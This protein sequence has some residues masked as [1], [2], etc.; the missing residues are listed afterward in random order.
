M[1]LFASDVTRKIYP[2]FPTE[3]GTPHL[4]YRK[5]DVATPGETK[6]LQLDD[7]PGTD[8]FCALYST[9]K[10]DFG[11]LI[12]RVEEA[13]GDFVTRVQTALGDDLIPLDEI[14][15]AAAGT[16]AFSGESPGRSAAFLVVEMEHLR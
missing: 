11:G 6:Y 2:L 13:K 7:R 9:K 15:Y 3:G 5:N 12:R 8:S 14:R 4:A 16:I 1:Y 10:L